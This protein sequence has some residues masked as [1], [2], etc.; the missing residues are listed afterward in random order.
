MS[1]APNNPYN[2][3]KGTKL[4]RQLVFFGVPAVAAGGTWFATASVGYTIGAFVVTFLALAVIVIPRLPD[5]P[6]KAS[7]TDE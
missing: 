6:G 1:D 7:S 4:V 5:P 3:S 2:A